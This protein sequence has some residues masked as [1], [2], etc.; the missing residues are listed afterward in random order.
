M[1][2]PMKQENIT[3]TE[4]MCI[5]KMKEMKKWPYKEEIRRVD[6]LVESAYNSEKNA[7]WRAYQPE[8]RDRLMHTE[9]SEEEFNLFDKSSSEEDDHDIMLDEPDLMITKN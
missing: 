6:S 9:A 5:K 4:M 7:V 1:F 2:N 8:S 3:F